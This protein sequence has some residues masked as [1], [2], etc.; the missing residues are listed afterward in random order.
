MGKDEFISYIRKQGYVCEAVN[1][2]PV[3]FLPVQAGWKQEFEK[4]KKLGKEKGYLGSL[5][6]KTGKPAAEHDSNMVDH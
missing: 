1:Q 4:I 2:V 5:G 6:I 3:I